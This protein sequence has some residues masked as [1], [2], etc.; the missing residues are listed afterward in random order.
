MLNIID[1]VHKLK[2]QE[3][4]LL[5]RLIGQTLTSIRCSGVDLNTSYKT[6]EFTDSINLSF[7]GLDE[8][9]IVKADFDETNFGNNFETISL[10][11]AEYPANI[12]ITDKGYLQH[13]MSSLTVN[14]LFKINKI[15]VYGYSYK[16][17]SEND[18]SEPYWQIEK[19]NPGQK[20]QENVESEDTL[21]FSSEDGRRLMISPQGPVPWINV[22]FDEAT[23]DKNTHTTDWSGAVLTKLK[24]TISNEQ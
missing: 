7:I 1:T 21:V 18:A 12:K 6:Y 10:Y 3:I 2:V 4:D 5:E 15:E 9:V 24:K 17:E 23:I 22:V 13:P 14:P 19:A 8:F 11:K 16:S 20:I